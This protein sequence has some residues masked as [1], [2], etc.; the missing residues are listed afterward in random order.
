M[1]QILSYLSSLSRSLSLSLSIFIGTKC[2]ESDVLYGAKYIVII[3]T[4]LQYSIQLIRSGTL[5]RDSSDFNPES[6]ITGTLVYVHSLD[7]YFR[8]IL[9]MYIYRGQYSQLTIHPPNCKLS[10]Y[11]YSVIKLN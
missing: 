11:S 10:D 6:R 9:H 2:T 7:L 3:Y 8:Y 5:I 1:S 4:V